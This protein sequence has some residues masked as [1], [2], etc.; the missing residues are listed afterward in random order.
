MPASV[1][2]SRK[3]LR[4][5]FEKQGFPERIKK[6]QVSERIVA[7][8]PPAAK[9]TFLPEGTLSQRVAYIDG[10]GQQCA[11]VHRFKKPDGTLGGSGMPD[12]KEVMVDGVLYKADPNDRS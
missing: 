2:I 5:L 9:S 10:R 12:P 11:I 7:S 1:Y 3:E 8:A 6:G 4:Q